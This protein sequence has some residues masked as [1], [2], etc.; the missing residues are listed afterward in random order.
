M[1]FRKWIILS[2]AVVTAACATPK[3]S[4]WLMDLEY[5]TTYAAPPAPELTIQA[6]DIVYI[7]VYSDNSTLAAPFN[8]TLAD[9]NPGQSAE[10]QQRPYIVDVDGDIDFPVFGLIN[11]A[12]MTVREVKEVIAKRISEQG[13]IKDPVVK[14]ALG[15]YQVTLIGRTTNTVMDVAGCSINIIQALARNGGILDNANLTD[16]M[17]IR[18]RKGER[19]A[20][21]VNIRSK[22]IYD[23]PVF[24]LQQNDII[25]V[26]PKGARLNS[27]G[28]MAMSF[29][30][31]GLTLASIITNVILW[32]SYKH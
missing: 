12:D 10:K 11:V 9:E 13:Y 6:G 1:G 7:Q 24:W 14:V 3:N 19:Q 15:K 22:D 28:Q 16:I 20:Y 18:T 4:S 26:K 21:S 23:S 5:E 17:V 29:V 30:S 8:S 27:S 25:Y 2:L 31:A 32:R